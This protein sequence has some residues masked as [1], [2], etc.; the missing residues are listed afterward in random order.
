MWGGG[1]APGYTGRNMGL[2][3]DASAKFDRCH[4]TTFTYSVNENISVYSFLYSVFLL[5]FFFSSG[6]AWIFIVC[7]TVIQIR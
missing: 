3:L 7:V 5:F 6:I 4:S 2:N 1:G